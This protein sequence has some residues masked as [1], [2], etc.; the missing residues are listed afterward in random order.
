MSHVQVCVAPAY[1]LRASSALN[2]GMVR[3][4]YLNLPGELLIS[5]LGVTSAAWRNLFLL[6][7]LS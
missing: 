1:C 4:R 2:C 7:V 3:C 5:L 6:F